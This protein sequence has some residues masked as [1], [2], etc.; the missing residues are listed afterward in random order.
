MTLQRQGQNLGPFS[1]L[2]SPR[3][4]I[5]RSADPYDTLTDIYVTLMLYIREGGTAMAVTITS[6][7][8]DTRLAD[9]GA[10][11]LGVKTRTGAVLRK[12]VA[13]KK[14]KALMGRHGGKMRFEGH[15]E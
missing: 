3:L 7:R 9:E 8:L 4:P 10:R 13:L 12:I 15:G 1:Q 6:L 11:V 2:V 5:G 14:L